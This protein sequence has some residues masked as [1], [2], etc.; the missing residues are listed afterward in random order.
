MINKKNIWFLTLFSLV[1]VLS[2]YYITMPNDVL[3]KTGYVEPEVTVNDTTD[4]SLV[5]ARVSKEEKT[6]EELEN[7]NEILTDVSK[8]S[9]EKNVAYE[10]MKNLNMEK[11]LEEKLEKK[12][13]DLYS[14]D[15]VVNISKDQVNV[16]ASSEDKNV[17]FANNIM[18]TIA[19]EFKEKK[20]VTVKFE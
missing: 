12:L 13:K 5:A 7:L 19:S 8:S 11:A 20:Y 14:I 6:L 2:V 3:V 10:K 17:E 16:S 9:E 15:S 18:H 1:L 4:T